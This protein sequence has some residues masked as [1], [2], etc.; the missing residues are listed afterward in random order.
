MVVKALL[1]RA[2]VVCWVESLAAE[3]SWHRTAITSQPSPS[4][5]SVFFGAYQPPD[6]NLKTLT[7]PHWSLPTRF[8]VFVN[9]YIVNI[10][11]DLLCDVNNYAWPEKWEYASHTVIYRKHR[12]SLALR[13]FDNL[14]VAYFFGTT[15][16]IWPQ[17]ENTA[18]AALYVTDMAVVQP[19]PQLKPALRDCS[20][21][22]ARSCSI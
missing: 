6:I 3:R 1:S 12:I 11:R 21:T 19:R 14:V 17:T 13:F 15:L 10:V 2:S 16:Y 20:Q 22:A 8:D 5:R 7:P 18:S 4:L 9:W